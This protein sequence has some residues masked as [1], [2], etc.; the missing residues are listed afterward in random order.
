MP[1]TGNGTLQT[2]VRLQLGGLAVGPQFDA[3]HTPAGSW[4]YGVNLT[5][6]FYGSYRNANVCP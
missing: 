4:G 2:R 1:V 5:A 3:C 6:A